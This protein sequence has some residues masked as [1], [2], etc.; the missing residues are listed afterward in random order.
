MK[1][2]LRS[3]VCVAVVIVCHPL[4]ADAPAGD[5]PQLVKAVVRQQETLRELQKKTA[6]V[7]AQQKAVS[8][9]IENLRF[10]LAVQRRLLRRYEHPPMQHVVPAGASR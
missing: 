3:L 1:A 8:A 6:A 2:M 10:V 5:G 9:E 4:V 7:T